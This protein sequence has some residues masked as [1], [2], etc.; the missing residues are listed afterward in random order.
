VVVLPQRLEA[1]DK[2]QQTEGLTMPETF[3]SPG[4]AGS[5]GISTHETPRDDGDGDSR[6]STSHS[7]SDLGNSAVERIERADGESVETVR[8]L[9]PEESAKAMES[10]EF[11]R[12]CDRATR[13]VVRSVRSGVF[14]DEVTFKKRAEP[15][16]MLR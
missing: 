9:S 10:P 16:D 7:D 13:L 12:F 6:L 14:A 5:R 8:V 11:I 4:V 2:E 1:Y 3:S 15:S